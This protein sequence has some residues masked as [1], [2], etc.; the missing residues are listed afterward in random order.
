MII[1]LSNNK[2]IT[3]PDDPSAVSL[4]ERIE[5]DELIGNDINERI[6]QCQEEVKKKDDDP[7]KMTEEQVNEQLDVISLDRIRMTIEHFSD[8]TI[9]EV[10]DLPAEEQIMLFQ[11]H[12]VEFIDLPLE[13]DDTR[14]HMVKDQLFWLP[15]TE[16]HPTTEITFNEFITAKEITRNLNSC[17]SEKL[18]AIALLGTI[19]FR[20]VDQKFDESLMDPTSD[21]SDFILDLPLNI[22]MQIGLWFDEWTKNLENQFSLFQ[23]SKTKG[24]DMSAHFEKWGWI[25]FM[26]YVAKNGTIFHKSNDKTNLQNVKEANLYD[27]LMWSSCEKDQEEIVSLHYEEEARKARRS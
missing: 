18:Q 1:K 4:R 7:T 24:I 26:N 11:K 5:Y 19:F 20:P 25:S 27:V 17:A 10:N 22:A 14:V 23:K 15:D 21:K 9:E 3:V 13:R 6:K 2:Q 12:L 8:M 16:L